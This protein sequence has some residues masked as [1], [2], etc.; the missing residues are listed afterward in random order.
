MGCVADISGGEV[1]ARCGPLREG[2]ALDGVQL[3]RARVP[4]YNPPALLFDL[5]I[6]STTQRLLSTQTEAHHSRTQSLA[7]QE[8]LIKG[9]LWQMQCFQH[10]PT[11]AR[12]MW[13]DTSA[14]TTRLTSPLITEPLHS[15]CRFIRRCPPWGTKGR[16]PWRGQR[17]SWSSAT[18]AAPLPPCSVACHWRHTPVPSCCCWPLPAAYTAAPALAWAPAS[19]PPPL[20]AA[21]TPGPTALCSQQVDIRCL[22][23]VIYCVRLWYSSAVICTVW[24]LGANQDDLPAAGLPV[25]SYRAI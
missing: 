1:E 16:R 8:L 11:K 20:A 14:P 9:K 18:A 4:Q 10:Q 7:L 2:H 3:L 17:R 5:R 6:P 19:S 24:P 22:V 25:P 15:C 12:G 13:A 23:S 21:R